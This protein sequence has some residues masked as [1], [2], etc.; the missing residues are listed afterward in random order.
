M[1]EWKYESAVYQLLFVFLLPYFHSS[2]LSYLPFDLLEP[3]PYVLIPVF[4]NN[5]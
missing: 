3:D 2:I 5:E 4:E 1:E